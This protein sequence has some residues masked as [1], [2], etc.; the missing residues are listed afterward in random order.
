MHRVLVVYRGP[1]EVGQVRRRCT[2]PVDEPLEL[3][4]CLVL[5]PGSDGFSDGLRAQKEITV[6]LRSAL[7]Q[8]A[9]TVAVFVACEGSPYDVDDC[10]REWGAT[11]VVP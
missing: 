3:A 10:A 2:L 1:I 9:E 7:G 4:L 11:L 8:R 5:P 6:A